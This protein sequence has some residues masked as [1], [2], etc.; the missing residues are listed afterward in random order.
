MLCY[1]NQEKRVLKKRE[2]NSVKYHREAKTGRTGKKHFCLVINN[3]G[4][5][6]NE[7]FESQGQKL[8]EQEESREQN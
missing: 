6:F 4:L 7:Q 5:L 2:I 8:K 1:E 3:P